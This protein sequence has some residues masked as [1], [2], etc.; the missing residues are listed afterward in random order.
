M[1]YF[2]YVELVASII[3]CLVRLKKLLGSDTLLECEVYIRNAILTLNYR[4]Y[5]LV[6]CSAS[7]IMTSKFAQ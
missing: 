7:T 2:S 4:H 3:N 5:I 6:V 1:R